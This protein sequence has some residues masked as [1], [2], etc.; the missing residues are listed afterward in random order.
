MLPARLRDTQQ[1]LDGRYG[2]EAMVWLKGQAW[3]NGLR[4]R[5]CEA[6][7]FGGAQALTGSNGYPGVGMRNIVFAENCLHAEGVAVVSCDLGG[8][9]HRYLRF[10][11]ANGDVW[12]RHGAP[13]V[14][15]TDWGRKAR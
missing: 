3:V 14:L 8:Q 11:L 5:D 9:G 4:I 6:K 7:L 2:E 15:P 13:L 1:S 10:D 12:V